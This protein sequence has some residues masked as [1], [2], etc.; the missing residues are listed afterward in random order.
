MRPPTARVR[1]GSEQ[2]SGFGR[3]S[4]PDS[5]ES[6]AANRYVIGGTSPARRN[7]TSPLT[8]SLAGGRD[9]PRLEI[10]RLRTTWLCAVAEMIGLRA[11][12][13]AAGITCSQRL[14]D[15]V[16]HVEPGS[17]HDAVSVLGG[18]S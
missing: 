16:A 5:S 1:I 17:A 6:A 2:L 7:V 18:R 3:N 15:L 12:M 4:C 10:A 9:L 11:F 8:A 13:D 14:G